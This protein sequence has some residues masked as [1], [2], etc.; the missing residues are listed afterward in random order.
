[1]NRRSRILIVENDGIIASDLEKVL[2]KLRY[3]VTNVSFSGEDALL[4]IEKE[5]PDIILT[6]TML[7]GS[8]D[9]VEFV[10]NVNTQFDIPVIFLSASSD[11]VTIERVKNVKSY[12]FISKPFSEDL[13]HA[14]I[15][16]AIYRHR[17]DTQ[18]QT[19]HPAV[20]QHVEKSKT[21]EAGLQDGWTRATFIVRKDLLEKMKAVAYWDRK[22]VKNVVDEALEAY[23]RDRVVTSELESK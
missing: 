20:R 3:S 4:N 11:K 21:S 23:L 15:E 19:D 6:E 17:A 9:G 13:M 7:N 22:K 5:R 8:M 10:N 1:M 12:G 16:T 2:D 18:K 14:S